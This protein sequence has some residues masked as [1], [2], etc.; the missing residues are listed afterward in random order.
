[1]YRA[2][3]VTEIQRK[4][5]HSIL[6]IQHIVVLL[7]I[8]LAG[9]KPVSGKEKMHEKYLL[10]ILL[11]RTFFLLVVHKFL[12]LNFKRVFLLHVYTHKYINIYFFNF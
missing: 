9:G 4:S 11:N 3:E 12:F 2:A 8:F 6:H 1:M 5:L 7:N 10:E